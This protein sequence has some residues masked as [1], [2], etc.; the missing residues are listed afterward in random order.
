[1]F[2]RLVVSFSQ[3]SGFLRSRK[4][5]REVTGK[6]IHG[7]ESRS[8]NL[9]F[10][11]L[12]RKQSQRWSI[13]TAN[14]LNSSHPSESNFSLAALLVLCFC[15]RLKCKC[16]RQLRTGS[17]P[18]SYRTQTHSRALPNPRKVRPQSS[19]FEQDTVESLYVMVVCKAVLQGRACSRQP[20]Q[21]IA[22]G[23]RP[24]G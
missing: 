23:I 16:S 8:S 11:F 17:V 9:W 15:S 4:L 10:V 7:S 12:D 6:Y 18:A 5:L 22:A 20:C 13:L 24:H 14:P 19:L 1:M 21:L 2:R 3:T